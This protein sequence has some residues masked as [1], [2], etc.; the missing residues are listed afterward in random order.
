MT[1]KDMKGC[2]FL[3][4]FIVTVLLLA[5]L[6]T[7]CCIAFADAYSDMLTKAREY[8]SEGDNEKAIVSYQLVQ[9]I[10][11]ESEEGFHGEAQ[12]RIIL[13]EYDVAMSLVDKMLDINPVSVN[14][15][16][17]KCRIDVLKN[18]ITAFETDSLFAEVCDA[19]FSDDYLLIALMYANVGMFEKAVSY[20]SLLDM[21]SLSNEHKE[22]YRRALVASG[23]RG[24]A[25]ALGLASA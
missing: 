6:T 18:D 19:D 17:L 8:Q 15:W 11:P 10:N 12:I 13:G 2:V 7:C 22:L 25:E 1:L 23:K 4:R 3:K 24:N 21:M 20:F 9:K 5:L 16:S 14:A